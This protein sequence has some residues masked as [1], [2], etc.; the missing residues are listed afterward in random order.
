MSSVS[1][2]SRPSTA[3]SPSP[4]GAGCCALT[5]P[6][7]QAERT[8]R[9]P[10]Q[11][12]PWRGKDAAPQGPCCSRVPSHRQASG[13]S[14]RG[15]GSPDRT[16]FPFHSPPLTST[17]P[18]G[19]R[20][21]ALH[22][23]ECSAALPVPSH[24]LPIPTPFSERRSFHTAHPNYSPPGCRRVGGS[25]RQRSSTAQSPPLQMRPPTSAPQSRTP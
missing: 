19:A 22:A 3:S 11:G 25:Q 10:Q 8:P 13:T 1:T 23:Q 9:A 4:W 2:S 15:G 17:P 6:G 12:Q 18:Q 21:S 24:S 5:S 16:G 20:S 7:T 14:P